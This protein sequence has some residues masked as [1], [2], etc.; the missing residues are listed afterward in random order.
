MEDLLEINRRVHGQHG[1]HYLN[2]DEPNS[3]FVATDTEFTWAS[4]WPVGRAFPGSVA[5]FDSHPITIIK[6]QTVLDTSDDTVLSN[7]I[8]HY[9][10]RLTLPGANTAVRV[11]SLAEYKWT[12]NKPLF[13][14][15]I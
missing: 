15:Y 4:S 6:T 9:N 5:Q 8:E 12:A 13:V 2:K 1:Q 3:C 11:A 14:D 10:L 7:P